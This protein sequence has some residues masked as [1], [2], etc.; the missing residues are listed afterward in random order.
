MTD[1]LLDTRGAAKLLG[2]SKSCLDKMRAAG[3]GPRYARIGGQVRYD[4]EDV[5]AFVAVNKHRPHEGKETSV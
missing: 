1:D 2:I 3:K 5:E 4:H